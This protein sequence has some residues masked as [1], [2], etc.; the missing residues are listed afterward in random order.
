MYYLGVLLGVDKASVWHNSMCGLERSSFVVQGASPGQLAPLTF[1][2][3]VPDCVFQATT[4]RVIVSVS[5]TGVPI[6]MT[7][8]TETSTFQSNSKDTIDVF[9]GTTP[10]L[11]APVIDGFLS[12]VCANQLPVGVASSIAGF[13]V[14]GL[15]FQVGLAITG[16]FVTIACQVPVTGLVFIGAG[17]TGFAQSIPLNLGQTLQQPIVVSQPCCPASSGR[18]LLQ[19]TGDID[20]IC[21][22]PTSC[23]SYYDYVDSAP[24][25][26]VCPI[27][28]L[29]Q[30]GDGPVDPLGNDGCPGYYYSQAPCP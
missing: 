9:M 21:L 7:E 23:P 10:T 29:R 25:F 30:Y 4:K 2:I 16:A 20:N 11:P 6:T 1:Q 17:N 28:D 18:H 15:T 14:K 27:A 24:G 3:Q 22:Y 13:A 26:N 8:L 5:G 19:A 12:A